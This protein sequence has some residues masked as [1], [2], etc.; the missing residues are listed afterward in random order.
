MT[1]GGDGEEEV[2]FQDYRKELRSLL[3][4]VGLKRP[5]AIINAIEPWTAE[6]ASGGSSISINKV[7]ALLHI[8]FHLHE[9]IPVRFIFHVISI[10]KF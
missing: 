10:T 1:V 7:E 5:E 2:E 4:V 8:V 6:V 9:I 3:N